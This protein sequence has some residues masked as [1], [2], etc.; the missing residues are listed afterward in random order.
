VEAIEAHPRRV[1]DGSLHRR[2]PDTK[3]QWTLSD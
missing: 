2:K 3:G 1:E